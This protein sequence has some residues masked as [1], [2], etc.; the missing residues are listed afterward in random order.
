[1]RCNS[2]ASQCESNSD[3]SGKVFPSYDAEGYTHDEKAGFSMFLMERCKRVFF[4]RH[5]EGYHNLAEAKSKMVPKNAV[6][7]KENSGFVYWDPRLTP[8]GEEQCANLKASIRGSSIW[9]YDMPLRLDLVIVSPTTRTLQTAYLS[10]GSAESPQAPPFV[11][12]EGCREQISDA[13]CDGRRSIT[14]LKLEFPGVDFSLVESDEDRMFKERKETDEDVQQRAVE[15][16]Q[17][18][19]SRPEVRIAVVTHSHFLKNLLRQFGSEVVEEDQEY[20]HGN[21]VNAEMRSVMICAHR[22]FGTN[23]FSV[24]THA[25]AKKVLWNGTTVNPA[26]GNTK[27]KP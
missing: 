25:P 27:P 10:L 17:F 12:H 11:A 23:E 14:E 9:G 18:L 15:F 19:C 20:L 16:L 22:K 1:M 4:I 3:R 24:R 7:L 2:T 5:A 21:W 8:R 26:D 6:L 13:M